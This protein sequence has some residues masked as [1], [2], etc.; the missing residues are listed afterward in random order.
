MSELLKNEIAGIPGIKETVLVHL[1]RLLA[2]E[3]VA[4]KHRDDVEEIIH[5][6]DRK[7]DQTPLPRGVD[8]N[9][10]RAGFLEAKKLLAP[11]NVLFQPGLNEDL[12]ATAIWGSQQAELRN[13]HHGAVAPLA[14]Q[15]VEILR[16]RRPR[17]AGPARGVSLRHGPRAPSTAC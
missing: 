8:V 9:D 16:A 10:A 11:A 1:V 14:A 15:P 13:P 17:R 7:I 4:G 6:I 5:A 3:L 12:A 2:A